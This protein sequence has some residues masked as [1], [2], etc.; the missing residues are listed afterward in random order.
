[1]RNVQAA[2]D[3][4]ADADV[5]ILNSDCMVGPEWLGRLRDAAYCDSTV[6]T[7]TALTNHGTIL[8]V[9][10]RNTPS[11]RIPEHLDIDAVARLIAVRSNRLRPRIPTAIGHCVYVRRDALELVGGFDDAFSPGYGEEV[12]FSQRCLA[13]GLLHVAA[14][15]VFVFHRGTGSFEKPSQIQIEHERLV[16]ARHP[17][18]H[19]TVKFVEQQKTGPLVR[20]LETAS[21]AVRPMSVTIDCRFL[22]STMTGTQIQTLELLDALRQTERVDLRVLVPRRL[23]THARA[24]LDRLDGIEVVKQDDQAVP[25]D[26]VHRPSQLFAWDELRILTDLGARLVVTALDLISYR[27]PT[28]HASF[29]EW[30]DYQRLTRLTLAI[31][32]E[33]VFMSEHARAD[34]LAEALVPADR[35]HVVPL[36]VDHNIGGSHAPRRPRSLPEAAQE[37]FLLCIGTNFRHKN[38]PFALRVLEQLQRRH[39]W[40]GW[41][42]FAGPHA[43]RG[44]SAG[45]EAEFLSTRPHVAARTCDIRAVAEAEKAWL[46]THA[47]GVLYPT[48]YEG[49]GLVPFEAAHAG[50]PCFFAWQ[51]ALRD[52][53]PESAALVVPWSAEATA[54]GIIALLGGSGDELVAR[55]RTAAERLTWM[56]TADAMIDVYARAVS[57]PHS[58]LRLL[59]D[60]GFPAP[61]RTLTS[62][63]NPEVL[64]VEPQLYR[65]LY[66]LTTN[67]ITRRPFGRGVR[68]AYSIGYLARRGR[69]PERPMSTEER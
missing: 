21:V 39:N 59:A 53:L 62:M 20:A 40:P 65:A 1:V 27:N 4:L 10:E 47:A 44:T 51:A 60:E 67:R 35:A 6:A 64:D 26:V 22:G 18:Y 56:H 2:F 32:D 14:D 19:D 49:F 34:A 41:L 5:V 38:R 13:R 58:E 50:T 17:C 57:G 31:A 11:A 24:A 30:R 36:G 61:L 69:L 54:D 45:E 15:D 66:K 25:T 63:R 46:L 29:S 12:D 9:P 3:A 23:G 8:S 33:V 37:R 43:A 16:R 55:I 28:Y 68:A 52:V 42:V 7:A 48:T